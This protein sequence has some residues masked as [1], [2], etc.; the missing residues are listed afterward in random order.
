MESPD[1]KKALDV[2]SDLGVTNV[3]AEIMQKNQ[4]F[5]SSLL[6][7]AEKKGVAYLFDLMDVGIPVGAPMGFLSKAQQK[8]LRE[9]TAP[10]DRDGAVAF[11]ATLRNPGKAYKDGR[12]I[13]SLAQERGI[14]KKQMGKFMPEVNEAAREIILKDPSLADDPNSLKG[15]VR[16]RVITATG[17][18]RVALRY[19]RVAGRV[20]DFGRRSVRPKHPIKING[21]TYALSDYAGSMLSSPDDDGDGEGARLIRGPAHSQPYRYLWIFDSDRGDLGMFRVTDGSEKV[22]GKADR[23]VREIMLLD[24]KGELNRVSTSEARSITRAM[25]KKEDNAL[26]ELKEWS[27]ELETDYQQFVNQVAADVFNAEIAPE[28]RR[29]LAEVN[30]GVV[31]FG[32]KVVEGLLNIGKSAE[33]QMQGHVV[34]QVL[35]GFTTKMIDAEVRRRGVDPDGEDIQASYWALNDIRDDAWER[36][37]PSAR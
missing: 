16:S 1:Y 7:Y 34:S 4:Q 21:N 27:K 26:S 37:V 22:W 36:F 30:Q 17:A 32:F 10:M 20:L 5:R 24:R 29:R 14:A 8:R 25:R 12:F 13:P 23:M 9:I 2:M 18:R 28:I 33:E 11:L 6:K 3:I 15:A 35:D 19:A 31:P